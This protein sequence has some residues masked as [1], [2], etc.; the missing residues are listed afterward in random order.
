MRGS[1]PHRADAR[2]SRNATLKVN[3]NFIPCD[4][5]QALALDAPRKWNLLRQFNANH[6]R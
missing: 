2:L 4:L 6:A 1:L 5:G 3:A